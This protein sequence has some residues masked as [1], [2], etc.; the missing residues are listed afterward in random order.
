MESYGSINFSVLGGGGEVGANC[1]Q[2]SIDGYRVLLD[3]GTHPKKDG[4]E[5]LPAFDLLSRPPDAYFISHGH[6]DHCGAVPYLC[7][8]FPTARG[9]ATVP[10]VSIIDRM[11][12]NSVVVMEMLAK[13]RGIA[14]YPLFDHYDVGYAMRFLSGCDFCR[15]FAFCEGLDAQAEFIHAG[16]VLGGASIL[17]NLPGHTILY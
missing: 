13:E 2:L 8:Q 6:V 10:S 5:C 11:L 9:Y 12:H 1:F 7:K 4:V 14:D 16:H 3:C 17:F 15:P